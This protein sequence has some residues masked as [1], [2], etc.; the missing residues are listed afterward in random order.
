MFEHFQHSLTRHVVCVCACASSQIERLE[1]E[2]ME[3]KKQIRHMV[4]ERGTSV[5][6][7]LYFPHV[8]AKGCS[9]ALDDAVGNIA[10]NNTLSVDGLQLA[11]VC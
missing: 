6:T 5:F 11:R 8:K 7:W 3:L 2:R 1:E 9:A 10:C 4:K